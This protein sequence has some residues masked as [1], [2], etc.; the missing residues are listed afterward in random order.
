MSGCTDQLCWFSEAKFARLQPLLPGKV[1]GVPSVDD[2][3]VI[4]AILMSSRKYRSPVH[5]HRRARRLR[6]EA[7]RSRDNDRP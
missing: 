5:H 7:A 6:R 4:P 3:R 1:R 2:R